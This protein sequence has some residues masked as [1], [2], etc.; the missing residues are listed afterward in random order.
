MRY[1]H[2]K[3][4]AMTEYIIIV[5]IIAVSAIAIFGLFGD[6]I[7]RKIGGAIEALGGDD[8]GVSDGDSQADFENL[9]MD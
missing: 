9:G 1:W 6:T 7:K 8:P 4:Q 2:K 3:G 5:L